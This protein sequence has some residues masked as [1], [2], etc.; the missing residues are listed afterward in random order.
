MS[1]MVGEWICTECGADGY[2]ESFSDDEVGH[3]DTCNKC[4]YVDVYRE[5]A[6]SGEVI[7][8]YSGCDHDYSTTDED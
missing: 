7:E 8:D 2:H 4:G 3:I 1:S 6:E 5:D